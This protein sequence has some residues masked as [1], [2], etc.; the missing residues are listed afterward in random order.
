[1]WY[2][3]IA[4]TFISINGISVETTSG[5]SPYESLQLCQEH[6]KQL[7]E[8]NPSWRDGSIKIDAHCRG[9][10][11]EKVSFGVGEVRIKWIKSNNGCLSGKENGITQITCPGGAAA[12]ISCAA[13]T[14]KTV[15]NG[16]EDCIPK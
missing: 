16:Y 12:G 13:G 14:T 4:S 1:M 3:I 5:G 6:F 2:L 10:N 9:P 8:N 7:W 11:D 15:V